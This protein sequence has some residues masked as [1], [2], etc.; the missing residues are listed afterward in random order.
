ML[1]TEESSTSKYFH[2]SALLIRTC[3]S[4]TVPS[5]KKR[6][7]CHSSGTCSV[8][9]GKIITGK[10]NVFN[11]LLLAGEMAT[12]ADGTHYWNAF[13]LS[14]VF[15]FVHRGEKFSFCFALNMKAIPY[16]LAFP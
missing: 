8:L 10:S 2:S 3:D 15:T 7:N 4:E 6:S 1:S 11:Y 12:A 9:I 16:L 14:F 13:L 5:S